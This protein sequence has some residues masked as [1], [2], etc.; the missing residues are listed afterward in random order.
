M[1][2]TMTALVPKV[3]TR[4]IGMDGALIPDLPQL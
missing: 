1:S 2:A 3:P 4:V